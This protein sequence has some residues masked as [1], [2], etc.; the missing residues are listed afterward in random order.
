MRWCA[1][2]V[3]HTINM[4]KR[5]KG[6]ITMSLFK[7]FA[8]TTL[9]LTMVFSLAACGGSSDTATTEDGGDAAE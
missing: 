6:G 4:L 1:D 9:A 2:G 7:K 5:E 8:A 3:R